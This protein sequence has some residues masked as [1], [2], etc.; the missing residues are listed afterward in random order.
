MNAMIP[1]SGH[2]FAIY[3]WILRTT[4]LYRLRWIPWRWLWREESK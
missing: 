2:A 4:R 3:R 1:E